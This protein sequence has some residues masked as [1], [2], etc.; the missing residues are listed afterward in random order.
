VLTKGQWFSW[1]DTGFNDPKYDAMYAK[2][3][4][5]VDQGA[6][7]K[8]VWKME[9]YIA[10]RRPYINLVEEQLITASRKQWTGFYPQLGAYCKCYYTSP[11]L[12]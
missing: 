12:T 11:H 6:R 7:R 3:G 1:S 4:T 9:S 2:Q 5:L 8:L 10:Q